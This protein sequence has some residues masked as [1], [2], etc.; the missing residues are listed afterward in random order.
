MELDGVELSLI[1]FAPFLG[2]SSAECPVLVFIV[3]SCSAL[4]FV[5]IPLFHCRP[6]ALYL[7]TALLGLFFSSLCF[8]DGSVFAHIREGFIFT[9]HFAGA[10]WST[11]WSIWRPLWVLLDLI[12]LL[13][14]IGIN[15]FRQLE[16]GRRKV[17]LLLGPPP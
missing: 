10:S 9:S 12:Q 5:V 14:D 3:G 7:C 6:L 8:F 4:L 16:L 2:E 1:S 17:R 15:Y 11:R 13:L